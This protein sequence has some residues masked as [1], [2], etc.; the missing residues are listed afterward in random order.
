M[1]QHLEHQISFVR[2]FIKYV[3]AELL[4]ELVDINIFYKKT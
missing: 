3:L 1:H 4:F 2:F